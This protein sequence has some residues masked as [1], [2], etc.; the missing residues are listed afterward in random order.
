MSDESLSAAVISKCLY[1]FAQNAFGKEA[2]TISKRRLI[3][4][5]VVGVFGRLKTLEPLTAKEAQSMAPKE[6]RVL[7]EIITQYIQ[8]TTLF[9]HLKFSPSFLDGSSADALAAPVLAYFVEHW[10][11]FPQQLPQ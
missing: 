8:F 7:Y 1:D 11:P 9:G 4:A 6:H 10:F 3:L 5:R 2:R